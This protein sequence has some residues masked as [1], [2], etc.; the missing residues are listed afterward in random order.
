MKIENLKPARKKKLAKPLKSAILFN[1]LKPKPHF[2]Q[3]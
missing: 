3:I 2:Q 1:N